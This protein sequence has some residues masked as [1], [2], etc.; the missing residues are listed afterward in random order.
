M[1]DSI[2]Q[3]LKFIEAFSSNLE[4]VNKNMTSFNSK[5]ESSLGNFKNVHKETESITE[6]Y[7]DINKKAKENIKYT[8]TWGEKLKSVGSTIKN[9]ILPAFG[10]TF[11]FG[12]LADTIGQTLSLDKEMT[13]LAFR[14]GKTSGSAQQLK[15]ATLGVSQVTGIAT[16]KSMELVSE[17]ARLRVPIKDMQRLATDVARFSEITGVGG[18]ES[19]RLAGELSR[20][21]RLGQQSISGIL[22]GMVKVQKVIGLTEGEMSALGESIVYSSRM[23]QQMGKNAVAVERFSKGTTK[24]AAA[25]AQVGIEAQT[26]VQFVEQLLDPGRLEDNALLYAKLGV[27]I[28]DAISGNVDPGQLASKF[29]ALGQELKGMSGPAAA[30]MAQS[31]GMPLGQ[32]RQMAEMDMSELENALGGTGDASEELAKSQAEA[33][34][35]QEKFE[36]TMNRIKNLFVDVMDAFMPIVDLFADVVYGSGKDLTGMIKGWV[37]AFKASGGVEKWVGVIRDGIGHLKNALDPKK[38]FGKILLGAAIFVALA[39]VVKKFFG[40]VMFS[41]GKNIAKTI[42]EGVQEGISMGAQ[43][44]STIMEQKLGKKAEKQAEDLQRRLKMGEAYQS[45][46]K[47]ADKWHQMSKAPMFESGKKFAGFMEKTL[48]ASSQLMKPYSK[49]KMLTEENNAKIFEQLQMFKENKR[50]GQEM[51][52]Q[53]VQELEQQKAI[54]NERIKYLTQQKGSANLTG[55]ELIELKKLEKMHTQ[56]GNEIESTTIEAG[57]NKDFYNKKELSQIKMLGEDKL[58]ELKRE[59][60]TTQE[61]S[62]QRS[63]DIK[64]EQNMNKQ[65]ETTIQSQVDAEEAKLKIGQGSYSQLQKLKKEQNDITGIINQQQTEYREQI[66]VLKGAKQTLQDI[67]IVA[68]GV[69]IGAGSAKIL[70]TSGG[71]F[72]R[73]MESSGNILKTAGNALLEKGR[74][75]KK[76]LITGAKDALATIK[77]MGVKGVFKGL[78]GALFGRKDESGQKVGGGVGKAIGGAA[79][80]LGP[81]MLIAGMLMKMKPVQDAI[82]KVMEALKPIIEKL[83]KVFGDLITKVLG[84]LMPV[85]MILVEKLLMPLVKMLLP[86]LLE[87]LAFLLDVLGSLIEALGYVAGVFSKEV[88]DSLKELGGSMKDAATELR[89]AAQEMRISNQLESQSIATQINTNAFLKDANKISKEVIGT[90]LQ[91]MEISALSDKQKSTMN[92][93]LVI[94][95]RETANA[96][97]KEKTEAD[98]KLMKAQLELFEKSMNKNLTM[99]KK[100]GND[101]KTSLNDYTVAQLEGNSQVQSAWDKT[102]ADMIKG[103]SKE[104]AEQLA[105]MFKDLTPKEWRQEGKEWWGMDWNGFIKGSETLKDNLGTLL[106]TQQDAYAKTLG[107]DDWKHLTA[108]GDDT[109]EKVRAFQEKILKEQEAAGKELEEVATNTNPAEQVTT[110]EAAD[111]YASGKGIVEREKIKEITKGGNVEEQTSANTEATAAKTEEVANNTNIIAQNQILQVNKED[112]QHNEMMSLWTRKFDELINAVKAG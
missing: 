8:T 105:I 33:L 51:S 53:K 15:D 110:W 23:L 84:A 13:K 74:N 43:K 6:S 96:F 86:P 44:S 46:Q 4:K 73:F 31:L 65:I 67:K 104:E 111:L 40:K 29:K 64:K 83:G 7:D 80:T 2:T 88:G 48:R 81:M 47:I 109:L 56:I 78:K 26:A 39:L 82:A 95:L 62:K 21:G 79:K 28:E 69:D 61:M 54:Y 55:E 14:M 32:L 98:K 30:A 38:L 87:I 91:S 35:T 41:V 107:F 68:K 20:V 58:R 36:K 27:S 93:Q 3:H 102:L 85:I 42:S 57:K 70:E 16:E 63:L 101:V 52:T 5:L 66:E 97:T 19:A 103:K 71:K 37:D 94:A 75:M 11:G 18:E 10:L 25:F 72:K 49:L 1:A 22:A 108:G 112:E 45:T 92:A 100:A 59:A 24:L 17:L 76:V 34:S 89:I 50:I 90:D 106:L 60:T 12:V 77:Q 9:N 99:M